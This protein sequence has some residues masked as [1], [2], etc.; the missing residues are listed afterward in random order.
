MVFFFWY[1]IRNFV[2]QTSSDTKVEIISFFIFHTLFSSMFVSFIYS[3]TPTACWQSGQ[4]FS[5]R[6]VISNFRQFT[7]E[8][9]LASQSNRCLPLPHYNKRNSECSIVAVVCSQAETRPRSISPACHLTFV[10]FRKRYKANLVNLQTN[11]VFL[12]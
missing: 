2:T 3:D 8:L 12:A 5:I 6:F 4:L 9:V 11:L 7:F 1:D 10:A